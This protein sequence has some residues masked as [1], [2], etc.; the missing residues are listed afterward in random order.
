MEWAPRIRDLADHAAT[1]HVLF[2]NCYRDYAQVN[3]QL[4]QGLLTSED[5]H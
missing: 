3:A 1:T 4:L 2:N 5:T